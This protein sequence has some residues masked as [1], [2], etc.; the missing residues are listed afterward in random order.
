MANTLKIKRSAVEGKIPLTTDLQ[1]G[2]VAINTYDGKLFLKRNDG[3]N[4]FIVEVGG[5]LG[6]YVK[7]Q[8]GSTIAKGTLVRFA[9]TL[10][11][12]GKL[13]IAPFIAN[14]TYPSEY[15][16]GIVLDDIVNGGDGF[17]IDHGKLVNFNTSGWA[18]GTILYASATTAGALTSTQPTAPNNKVMIAAVV[19]SHATAG[20]LQIRITPGS[21]L[22]NDEL[23]ELS[24]LTNGQT[25]VYNST[26]QRF[27]NSTL[28]LEN[29][30]GAWIKKAVDCA[31]T[32][33]LTLNTAQTTI[34]GVT[35]SATSRVLVKNQATASQNGIYTNMTT[36]AWTRTS[37][38]DTVAKLAT[39]M[40]AVD[41]GTTNG[42]LTFDNDTKVTDTLGTTDIV[43]NRIVDT[44]LALTSGSTV[45]DGYVRYSGTTSTAGQ[46]NGGTTNPAGTT[47]LNYSGYFYPTFINLA[48][49]GD[50]TTAATHYFVET[51]SDGFVRPKTLANV[52]TE[53]VTNAA[54]NAAAA[55]T[56]GTIT[57]GVWNGTDIAVADG[58]TGASD[59]ATARTNLD[60][61][62]TLVSGTNI[63]TINGNT[64]LGSGDL[65]I[66]G[67]GGGSV[68]VGTAAP[69]S[70]SAG[71]LWWNSEEGRLKI[72]YTDADTSQ[73]VDASLGAAGADGTNGTNGTNGTDG[74]DGVGVPAG[75]TAGQ[76][77]VKASATDYD[78]A[79]NTLT[80]M[81][82]PDA[83]VKKACRVAT[84]ANITLS[85]TQTIDGI[86]VVA[87][88]RVL[89]KNQTTASQ[90]GIYDVSA[91]TWTRSVDANTASYLAGALVSVDLGTT[92]GG[93]VYDTDFK[94]TDTVGTTA[95]TWN[96]MLDEGASALYYRKNTST[97]LSS[98]T[99]NQSW[100]G[101]TNGVTVAAN[102]IY[103]FEGTFE[104]TTSG[105]TSHTE[106]LLFGLT[107]ATVTNITWYVTRNTNTTTA[108]AP[109]CNTFTAATTQTITGSITTS[110][111]VH[112]YIKGTV[113][114]GTG[115]Q[116]NPQISF[117][118]AP[119]GTSTI[120][121]GAYF[122]MTPLGTTGGNVSNG[123]WS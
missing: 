74:T 42:G 39:V 64:L 69:S 76:A 100:L 49:S 121:L 70:P 123:T 43:W 31:T 107:T 81:S 113:A 112:Y 71:A 72:Y 48:G 84:T 97:T 14:N 89:V 54:I 28:T 7:N 108:T 1:L 15:V 8:S 105:T 52:K 40:V 92:N 103:D 45:V 9:G 118:A 27:E 23:V 111:D 122:K 110:Q 12:S 3:T 11:S 116:F 68:S 41:G 30:P 33:A 29:L 104:L 2:E 44:G 93:K 36:T 65:V 117:S 119:G 82:L 59:A 88:D 61:Q 25:L 4:D 51:S 57:S 77:L 79:W 19:H 60:A 91:S 18:D 87:G 115:G 62:A 120:T 94:S 55:T 32:A 106:R 85:G 67:G 6:Y 73:W 37:D 16:M 5:N 99:S 35:L 58:G 80:L 56:V 21:K 96:R 75:G 10:G 98:S 83:W 17:V 90:N 114:F 13:L 22:N 101:L 53:I 46:F 66:S 20:V 24:S 109:I 63:K 95:M 50:T 102:T 34:D 47:R 86:A 78:T 38:A 26:N